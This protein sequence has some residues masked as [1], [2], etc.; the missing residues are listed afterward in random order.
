MNRWLRYCLVI[1]AVSNPICLHADDLPPPKPSPR[2]SVRSAGCLLSYPGGMLFHTAFD[3]NVTTRFLLL[4][5]SLHSEAVKKYLSLDENQLL[6]VKELRPAKLAEAND[7]DDGDLNAEPD[8]QVLQPDYFAFLKAEQLQKLDVLALR[9]D[10]Y[11]ALNRKSVAEYLRL[12]DAS[13]LQIEK[14]TLDVR[15]KIILP[16]FRWEFAAKLPKDSKYRS[17]LFAGSV[18]AQLNLRIV[19]TLTDQECQRL[20][21]LFAAYTDAVGAIEAIEKAAVLPDGI[22]TLR[23]FIK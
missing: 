14:M 16:Q 12:G 2:E 23:E 20:Q 19:D 10:G 6:Q 5:A 17:C 11:I 18:C 13:K 21:D 9:F 15:E 7:G 22:R 1:F 4:K 3:E 8:E